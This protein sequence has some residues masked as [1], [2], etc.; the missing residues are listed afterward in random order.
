MGTTCTGAAES[1]LGRAKSAISTYQK[2]LPIIVSSY[3]YSKAVV[4]FTLFMLLDTSFH[5]N[6]YF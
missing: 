2:Y 5:Q 3:H 6:R 1:C 4:S